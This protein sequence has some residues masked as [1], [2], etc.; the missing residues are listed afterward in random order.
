MLGSYDNIVK[1]EEVRRRVQEGDY[2]GAQK[3][4]DTMKL[5]RV[6]NLA[7]LSLLAEVLTQNKRY[8]EAME[9][10]NRVYK[11]SK[12]R[13]TL[14]QMVFASIG[15]KDIVDAERYL[16][17]YE[18]VAPN[19]YNIYIF[20][21]KIDKLKKEPYEVLIKSLQGLKKKIYMEKWAYELAKLYY[22]AGLEKECIKECSDIILWFG[23]GSYVEKAKILK[24]YYSGEVDKEEI[25]QNLKKR[26]SKADDDSIDGSKEII[27]E[28]LEH[29]STVDEI[30]DLQLAAD[31]EEGDD[32]SPVMISDNSKDD[33]DKLVNLSEE[34]DVD[35]IQIFSSFLHV[36]SI[37]SQLLKSIE[38]ITN[39]TTKSLQ[40]IITG[41]PASGKT[42]LAKYIAIF[43]NKIGK[44]S[45]SR[46]VKVSALK[47][48]QIEDIKNKDQLKGCCMVIENANELKGHTIDKIL[49]LIK[50]FHGDIAVIFEDNDKDMNKL[51][52]EEPKI[53]DMFENRIHLPQYTVEDLLG[54]VHSRIILEGYEIDPSTLLV[55]NESLKEII[56]LT[57]KDKQLESIFKYVDNAISY[58]NIRTGKQLSKSPQGQLM[59][60]QVLYLLLEDFTMIL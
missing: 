55:V 26:A 14:N 33:L 53:K 25:L 28:E 16:S 58:A 41:G 44:L 42:T 9:L 18:E 20:R 40:M 45:S 54:F 13:R 12:T 17:E 35:I 46:V 47:L 49:S 60:S 3:V 21:F 24:A 32:P 19:D 48:N 56:G 59:D 31:L 27:Q 30:E 34:L 7:D 10:L 5:K 57:R 23:E 29:S 38:L 2:E 39:N 50:Y 37:Q 43:L 22:K 51:F 6:K 11:K 36:S 4:I 8:D 15:R 1:T 52:G